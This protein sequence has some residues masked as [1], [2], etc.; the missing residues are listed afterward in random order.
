MIQKIV[1]SS[2]AATASL[3][4]SWSLG[5]FVIV[6]RHHIANTWEAWGFG[7]LNIIL[8][9]GFINLIFIPLSFYL[10]KS[11]LLITTL[12]IIF[13]I[14]ILIELLSLYYFSITLNLLDKSVFNFSFDQ[15][16]LIISAYFVF[17]WYYLLLPLP[18]ICYFLMYRFLDIKNV[19]WASISLIIIG[20]ISLFF[21]LQ[22]ERNNVNYADLSKNK[23]YHLIQSLST[24]KKKKTINLTNE[25]IK[26]YQKNV[27]QPLQNSTY[28]L[29]HSPIKTNPLAPFF[30]LKETP[31][32]IVFIVVEGLSSSFSGPRA[33]EISFTPFLDSLANHS[34]YFDN[35]LATSERSFAA[36]PSIIG[37][38]P[39]GEK[40]F[41]AQ[42]V[43]FP[44]NETLATWL[45]KNGYKGDFFFGGYSR[46]DNMDLFMYNQG[47]KNIYDHEEFNYEGTGLQTSIDEVPFGIS[48]KELF[49]E[50][51]KIT[52]K[53]ENYS[54]Y[55]DVYFT[56]S[57]HYPYFIDEEEKYK[58]LVNNIIAEAQVD[59]SIKDKASKYK[60]EFATFLFTDDA[61]RDYFKEKEKRKA[62][63]N[64]IYVIVGDHMMN[65]ITQNNHL[66]KYRSVLMIYSPLLN[67]S[68]II[69]GV[70]SHLDI[71][72]SFY[73]LIQQ[74]YQFPALEY[75]SWLGQPFDT[76]ST[77]NCE[78]N[79][80]FM[81]Y[82]REEVEM[83]HNNYFLAK[84]HIHKLSDRLQ[85]EVIKDEEK[86]SLMDKLMNVSKKV[87][88][89]MVSKNLL[90]P[91]QA[92]STVVSYSP[93]EFI[94]TKDKE[95]YSV[96]NQILHKPISQLKVE[97]DAIYGGDW[98]VDDSNDINP[99]LVY[100]L[101]RGEKL[102]SWNKYN[103]DITKIV[104]DEKQSHTILFS[105]NLDFQLEKGDEVNIYYWN[106][107]LS[108]KNFEVKIPSIIVSTTE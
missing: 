43:G 67:Q 57:M 70:N 31:P 92:P 33:D 77:F 46:F 11:K 27:N 5:L 83:V 16:S 72:P 20:L 84:N 28:I 41:T 42:P 87:H 32:N 103:L 71:A 29:L 8:I 21:P 96:F 106:S 38:L 82:S 52:D 86:K 24:Q 4:V 10:K 60:K 62:H 48:D 56:L 47:F 34:L 99:K 54:P 76:S 2:I 75:V 105:N 45:F 108:D 13:S 80:L 63:Q 12:H 73:N 90:I 65:E 58:E 88:A 78:K 98:I 14:F 35:S 95:F 97:I 3:V 69:K 91:T 53:R 107:E 93:K 9:I 7:V 37:S 23:T 36:L 104:D 79:V 68:K 6:N 64:T 19:K 17:K 100:V 74:E 102:L 1:N 59:Q 22:I 40:G 89:E 81:L 50:V 85:T 44:N 66:E 101:M 94:I 15:A 49:K 51:I 25:E 61:L 18:L 30:N 26:F 55:F 39:H